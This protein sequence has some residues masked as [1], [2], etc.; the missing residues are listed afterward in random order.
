MSTQGTATN[1]HRWHHDDYDEAIAQI[2]QQ[3]G[4][5][6]DF[7][8]FG[9]DVLVAVYMR[10]EKN[11]QG[12]Y[13]TQKQQTEDI[14][15]GKAV[16]ILKWGPSAFS[17]DESYVQAQWGDKGA[18]AAGDWVFLRPDQGTPI[19]LCGDGANRPQGPGIGGRPTDIWGWD[20]WP[21]RIVS[22]EAII[23]RMNKPH[24]VV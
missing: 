23:G 5:I 4:S 24:H 8:V 3:L 16:L 2:R 7:E 18:P 20:G 19:N 13:F 11:A 21:C 17:G 6:D 1:L 12:V 9:K 14:F 22:D 15:N 10:P